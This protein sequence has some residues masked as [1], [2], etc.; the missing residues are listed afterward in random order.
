M[1]VLVRVVLSVD[2]SY[3]LGLLIDPVPKFAAQRYLVRA[4]GRVS[5]TSPWNVVLSGEM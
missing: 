3:V 2:R 5:L 1:I 4:K